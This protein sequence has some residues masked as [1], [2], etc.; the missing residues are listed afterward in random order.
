[1]ASPSSKI[2][3]RQSL[4]GNLCFP[5]VKLQQDQIWRDGDDFYFI[6]RLERLFVDYKKITDLVTKKGEPQLVSKK[7]F[8]RLIKNAKLL[9]QEEIRF[10][11]TGLR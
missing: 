5:P 2:S 11:Q 9:T 7:E 8:C 10:E 3:Y 6:I 4:R 1:M